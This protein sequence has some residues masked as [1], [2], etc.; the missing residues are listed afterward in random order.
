MT[1]AALTRQPENLPF[2]FLLEADQPEAIRMNQRS[3]LLHLLHER[4]NSASIA[5]EAG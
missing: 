1:S 4:T 3:L 2:A 5:T